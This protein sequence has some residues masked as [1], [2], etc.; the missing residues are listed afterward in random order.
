MGKKE[1]DVNLDNLDYEEFIEARRLYMQKLYKKE[2]E[3]SW[4]QRKGNVEYL[5]KG[6]T[7]A[8]LSDFNHT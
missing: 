2:A 1:E 3:K 5:G 4:E 6:V 8:I 7:Y